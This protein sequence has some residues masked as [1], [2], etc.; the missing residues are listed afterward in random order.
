[1]DSTSSIFIVL[2]YGCVCMRKVFPLSQA[3][4]FS[5][6]DFQVGAV[7]IIYS[8]AW[9]LLDADHYTLRYMENEAQRY[10]YADFSKVGSSAQHA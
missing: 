5:D 9:E 7:L 1:M 6:L 10:P 4:F 8:R 3:E 2:V